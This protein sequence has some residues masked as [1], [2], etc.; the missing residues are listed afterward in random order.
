MNTDQQP[1]LPQ[2]S[3]PMRRVYVCHSPHE[4]DS[5]YVENIAEYCANVGID[6]RSVEIGSDGSVLLDVLQD[7]PDSV[8]GFNSLLD[9]AW[10]RSDPFL[11]IASNRRVPIIQWILDHPTTHWPQFQHST[12]TNS[13]YVF[14]SRHSEAY[15]RRFCLPNCVTSSVAGVGPNKRSR[16]AQLQIKAF[17]DREYSCLI[18]LN[19]TRIAGSTDQVE[20]RIDALEAKHRIAV[21]EAFMLARHDLMRPIETHLALVLNGLGISLTIAKF[22]SYMQMLEDK[23]QTYRRLYVF[24]VARKFPVLIQSDPTAQP[25]ADGGV[26]LFLENVAMKQTLARMPQAQAIVSVSHLNDMIHDRTL[27]GCNAGCVNI[28]E[29]SLA[30]RA[31]LKAGADALFFRYDDESLRECLALVCY[32]PKAVYAIAERGFALRDEQPFRFGG[33]H[34]LVTSRDRALAQ[35]AMVAKPAPGSVSE[36]MRVSKIVRSLP[37]GGRQGQRS[38]AIDCPGWEASI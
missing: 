3:L 9:H 28:V 37:A 2:K 11:T 34:N 13:R 35:I 4:N 25:F 21:L 31:F 1:R 29:D 22:H 8:I 10:I 33:Y 19:L 6:F 38:T 7:E 26:A 5:V 18:P 14:N 36:M 30:H 12:R 20:R 23:V 15:F 17:L 27:N 32:K 16:I 24:K